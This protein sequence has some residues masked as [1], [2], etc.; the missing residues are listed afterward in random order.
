MRSKAELR[1]QYLERRRLLTESEVTLKSA[2]ISDL[3][4]GLGEFARPAA[5]LSYVASKDNEVDTKPLIQYLLDEGKNVLVPRVA[6]GGLLTWSRLQSLDDLEA[7][8]YGILAPRAPRLDTLPQSTAPVLVPGIAFSSSGHRIGYGKG[9]F[10]RFLA[11][12]GGLKIGLAFDIQITDLIQPDEHDVA[13]DL[14]VTESRI[15]DC[16][17]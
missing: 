12:H 6:P 9:Y 15:Y 7:S 8:P 17:R 1:A 11:G 3:V 14:I 5:C 10:D 4:R 16:R 13:L 2:A